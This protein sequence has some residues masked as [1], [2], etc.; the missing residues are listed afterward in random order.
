MYTF[1][2]CVNPPAPTPSK[3][4]KKKTKQKKQTQTKTKQNKTKQ[5]LTKTPLSE[6]F[7]K[8]SVR[9]I[10]L[11]IGLLIFY[12]GCPYIEYRSTSKL[13]TGACPPKHSYT[14]VFAKILCTKKTHIMEPCGNTVQG[15]SNLL[16]RSGY[17]LH[18]DI[19]T[20]IVL[21]KMLKMITTKLR[22]NF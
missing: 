18:Q 14:V 10:V 6:K 4:N 1:G 8:L 19:R 21:Y 13:L 20:C 2:A 3:K 22:E 16:F 5:T 11:Y 15:D 17:Q 12:G 7:F 9:Y